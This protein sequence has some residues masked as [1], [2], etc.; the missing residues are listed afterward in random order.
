MAIEIRKWDAEK[1]ILITDQEPL[2]SLSHPYITQIHSYYINTSKGCYRTR[3]A[4]NEEGYSCLDDLV[5]FNGKSEEVVFQS[6]QCIF[7]FHYHK[8]LFICDRER[9]HCYVI[10]SRG[11]PFE[12]TEDVIEN[13][14]ISSIIPKIEF[15]KG[16]YLVCGKLKM[17]FRSRAQQAEYHESTKAEEE[18]FVNRKFNNFVRENAHNEN[19]YLYLTGGKSK[20]GVLLDHFI[21]NGMEYEI[22]PNLLLDDETINVRIP[23][24]GDNATRKEVHFLSAKYRSTYSIQNIPLVE[25]CCAMNLSFDIAKKYG[26]FFNVDPKKQ[27]LI[28]SIVNTL[29]SLYP[30]KDN[31]TVF[32]KI[33]E[34][35]LVIFRQSS[36]DDLSN[37]FSKHLLL[38]PEDSEMS[39]EYLKDQL[40]NICSLLEITDASILW[41]ETS[42]F[43]GFKK[44]L[45][46]KAN[47]A[48]WKKRREM[49]QEYEA[50]V[51]QEI[52]AEGKKV[53]RWVNE[54]DLYSMVVKHYSDAV[55]QY[56]TE[57]L[58]KQSLDVYIPSIKVGLEY[59]GAQHY[60]P[61][62]F[63][64]G[65]EAFQM[66]QERDKRKA[67]L[68]KQNGVTLIY[69]RYDEPISA[70]RLKT[71][72]KEAGITTV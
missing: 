12:F 18:A 2:L 57:W 52:A 51:L 1:D 54:G 68:C 61:I 6:V 60:E 15:Y 4:E 22:L 47:N 62:D 21:S 39:N 69:W 48:A 33:L 8:L 43:W 31:D 50:Q 24:F 41:D 5:L 26:I 56:R 46:I 66:T 19:K 36:V 44:D 25:I 37:D 9:R 63:F 49:I 53:S 3:K 45:Y 64:G 42:S 59:Q 70:S 32:K 55:F 35:F 58:G 40:S 65:E 67:E 11:I 7:V 38:Y 72:L 23:L 20:C 14:H 29:R 71:K 10:D 16:Y 28:F 30:D 34:K 17:Y 13:G 27:I